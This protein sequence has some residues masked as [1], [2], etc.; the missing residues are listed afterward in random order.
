MYV[1]V[2]CLL[3]VKIAQKCEFFFYA[4]EAEGIST[5]FANG[6]QQVTLPLR[7]LFPYL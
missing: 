5:H 7:I 1:S 4:S 2:L 6:H 3:T